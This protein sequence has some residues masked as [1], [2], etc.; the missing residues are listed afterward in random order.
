MAQQ[1]TWLDPVKQP[2]RRNAKDNLPHPIYMLRNNSPSAGSFDSLRPFLFL[3][4]RVVEP[5]EEKQ[6]SHV[7]TQL[8][9]CPWCG[10]LSVHKNHQHCMQ[11]AG[12]KLGHLKLGQIF[13][14]W[15]VYSKRCNKV[16]EVHQ[17]VN[18]TVDPCTIKRSSVR[19]AEVQ[20]QSPNRAD[21]Q[22]MVNVQKR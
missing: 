10:D 15:I 6:Q 8:Q 12:R 5:C 4:I 1:Q 17:C 18:H 2:S 20:Q 13:F 21:R 7:I 14:Q 22:M 9:Q 19:S 11:H 16:V 3:S